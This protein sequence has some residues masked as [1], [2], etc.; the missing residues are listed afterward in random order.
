VYGPTKGNQQMFD[1]V[2]VARAIIDRSNDS[3]RLND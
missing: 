2:V 1:K 3:D